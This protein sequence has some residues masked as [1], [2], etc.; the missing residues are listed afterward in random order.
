MHYS[1]PVYPNSY[2]YPYFWLTPNQFILQ[3]FICEIQARGVSGNAAQNC[4]P[5]LPEIVEIAVAADRFRGRIRHSMVCE[6]SPF[7]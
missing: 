5:K 7:L 3:T 4:F 2:L 1:F 6:A